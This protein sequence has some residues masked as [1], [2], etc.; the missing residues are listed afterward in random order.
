MRVQFCGFGAVQVGFGFK[1]VKENLT[2]NNTAAAA[3]TTQHL[4]SATVTTQFYF[5]SQVARPQM[6]NIANKRDRKMGRRTDVTCPK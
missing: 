6:S 4:R 1:P 2:N 5:D 3:A